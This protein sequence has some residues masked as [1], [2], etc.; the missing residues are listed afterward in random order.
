VQAVVAARDPMQLGEDNS[1]EEVHDS[2][3]PVDTPICHET[4]TQNL[5]KCRSQTAATLTVAGEAELLRCL[6]GTPDYPSGIPDMHTIHDP[7][8]SVS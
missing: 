7:M 6:V 4:P 2:V 8:I 3:P 5:S 1:S